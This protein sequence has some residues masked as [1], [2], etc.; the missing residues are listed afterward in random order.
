[1]T[2]PSTDP[3]AQP[4]SL[5]CGATLKNRLCKAAMTEGLGDADDRA[6]TRHETIY[7]RW[8]DGGAGLLLTGNVMIDRRFLERSG[9]VVIDQNGGEDELRAWAEAGTRNGTHLWM[10]ISHPGRQCPRL[11]SNKPVSASAVAIRGMLG[12]MA[13]PRALEIDEI[14]DVI[15]RFAHTAETAK[16]CG[17][18]GVQFHSAHGYLSSQFLSPRTNR[19]TDEW[20]G[21]LENRARFLLESIRAIREAV[22][23]AF[24]VAVKLN[25]S[26]FQ[27]GGFTNEEC[28]QVARWLC[29]AGI[30][31]L[32]LSGGTYEQL[33]LQGKFGKDEPKKAE[34]TQR[35]E[36]YFLDYAKNIRQVIH[37]VPLM[38]TG[39]FRSVPL[40]REVIASG[41]VDVVGLGRP[42]CVMPDFPNRVLAGE[43]DQLPAHERGQRLGPGLLGPASPIR[44]IRTLNSQAEVAWCYRQIISLSEDKEPD[45]ELGIWAALIAHMTDDFRLATRRTFKKKRPALPATTTGQA[46]TRS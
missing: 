15:A 45:L 5:P 1:M 17:F 35:R 34:S 18:T 44:S 23:P 4:L 11:S 9:N 13:K 28:A 32:E 19:R 8:A 16:R 25:S 12:T 40:M 3:L 29:E 31:L 36:A 26:D 27:K 2:N 46:G 38:V 14:H 33:A 6:T 37:G 39:G 30:D 41:E 42:F 10:Q 7:R 43:F 21:P 22:G 24:P 20:G